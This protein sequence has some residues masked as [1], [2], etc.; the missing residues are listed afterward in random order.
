M[1]VINS[2]K[3]RI[4]VCMHVLRARCSSRT[5]RRAGSLILHPD[6]SLHFWGWV[7][8]LCPHQEVC[9]KQI[10]D[11]FQS[12]LDRRQD[13]RRRQLFVWAEGQKIPDISARA[14]P[15]LTCSS[16]HH[17]GD[18]MITNNTISHYRQQSHSKPC[19]RNPRTMS[20]MNFL[21]V[22]DPFMKTLLAKVSSKKERVNIFHHKV[23]VDGVIP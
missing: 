8:R 15:I 18:V 7:V 3:E 16:T 12:Y 21:L 19:Y 11:S 9:Q 2:C 10:P 17:H 6:A 23:V 20:F 1:D 13:E 5:G 22:T 14:H 4:H